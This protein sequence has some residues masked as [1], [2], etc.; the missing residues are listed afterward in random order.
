MFIEHFYLL[1]NNVQEFYKEASKISLFDSWET[2]TV[3]YNLSPE[4][5]NYA[6]ATFSI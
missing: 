6:H 2:M 5:V 4:G 3:A 1:Q